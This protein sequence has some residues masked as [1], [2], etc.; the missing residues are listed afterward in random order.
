MLYVDLYFSVFGALPLIIIEF[1][2]HI[3]ASGFSYFVPLA[4]SLDG[5]LILCYFFF[6][7]TKVTN[8]WLAGI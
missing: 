1:L 5:Q 6:Y 7:N 8:L 3:Q 4:P 2:F